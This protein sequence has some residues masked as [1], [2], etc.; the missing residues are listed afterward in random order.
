MEHLLNRLK[1]QRIPNVLQSKNIHSY[2]VQWTSDGINRRDHSNYIAQFNED[3]C[4][5]IK[6]QID[7]CVQSRVTKVSDPLKHEILEHAIQCKTYVNKFHG[8]TDVLKKV[9]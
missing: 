7:N 5:A 6:E 4:N 2:H 3:F 8:R 9:I 1:S